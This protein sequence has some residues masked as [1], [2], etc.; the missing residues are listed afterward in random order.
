MRR[1]KEDIKKITHHTVDKV[2]EEY[3]ELEGSRLYNYLYS[4][5]EFDRIV[6]MLY[7]ELKSYRKVAKCTNRTYFIVGEIIRDFKRNYKAF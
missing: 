1:I 5:P 2:I 7:G 4:L 3:E 6:I